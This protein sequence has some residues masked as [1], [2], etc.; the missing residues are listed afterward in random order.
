MNPHIGE[1]FLAGVLV[2][3][4]SPRTTNG[5][6]S[7]RGTAPSVGPWVSTWHIDMLHTDVQ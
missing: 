2:R 3:C 6:V 7:L 1:R 4:H 5:R